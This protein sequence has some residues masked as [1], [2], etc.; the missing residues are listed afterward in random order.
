MYQHHSALK[1]VSQ[2]TQNKVIIQNNYPT[3]KKRENFKQIEKSIIEIEH[4]KTFK[5]LNDSTLSKFVTKI[6]V[7]RK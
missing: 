2:D 4:Y 6:M 1:W 7:L 5:F 3:R